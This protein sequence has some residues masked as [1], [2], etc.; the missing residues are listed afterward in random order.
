[1]LAGVAHHAPV[2]IQQTNPKRC[3]KQYQC[4]AWMLLIHQ[5]RL[6]KGMLKRERGRGWGKK[7]RKSRSSGRILKQLKGN[8]M[9]LAPQTWLRCTPETEPHTHGNHKQMKAQ[10][11]SNQKITKRLRKASHALT[12]RQPYTRLRPAGVETIHTLQRGRKGCRKIRSHSSALQH[13]FSAA[14]SDITQCCLCGCATHKN[15]S[16]L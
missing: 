8:G 10:H 1:M 6:T 2:R 9:K 4:Q 16:W 5:P 13:C 3:K 14:S 11:H 12:S 15:N 7:Q